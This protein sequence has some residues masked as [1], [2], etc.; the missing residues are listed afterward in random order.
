[1]K[2]FKSVEILIVED[3][4]ND[5]ELIV[6]ALKKQNLANDL[7]L[8]EDGEEALDFVYCRGKFAGHPCSGSLKVIFLDLKLPKV[9]GLE[10]LRELKSDISTK[11]IP[12][13]IITSS[14]EDPDI[15]TAYD[16][17]VNAYVVKPVSFEDF[18]NAIQK[19][20]LFW[21]L[22]NEAPK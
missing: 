17:G 12:I 6:R 18:V 7:Y 10:V 5:A 13:V 1:M 19:T 20:S 16:L 4:P 11:S 8:A 14:K 9:D 21:L 15:K 3:N 22:V 2:D